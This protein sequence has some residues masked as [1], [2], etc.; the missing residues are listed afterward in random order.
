MHIEIPYATNNNVVSKAEL[1]NW[2]KPDETMEES[3]KAV[4]E[5]EAKNPSVKDLIGE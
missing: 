1:R 2:L 5:L 3:Q 4:D